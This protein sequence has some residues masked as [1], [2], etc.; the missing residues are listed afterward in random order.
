MQAHEV[1]TRHVITLR[2]E[3]TLGH[4]I[5]LMLR[6]GI[7]GLPVINEH[8]GVV[9]ILTEGDMLRRPEIQTERSR[10][11]W[12]EFL[13]PP[14]T[15]AEEYVH[16]HSLRVMDVMSRHVIAVT[17]DAP[18]SQIV[19]LM[20]R[21]RIKRVPVLDQGKL[22]GIVCRANLIHMLAAIAQDIPG[23]APSDEK[24]RKHL[25]DELNHTRWASWT[26]HDFFVKDGIVDLHGLATDQSEVDALRVAAENIPG[27]KM[28][29]INLML[30]DPMSGQPFQLPEQKSFSPR[31]QDLH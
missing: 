22:V 31:Q 13:V 11:R 8:G 10:S 2:P 24:I 23:T 3:D 29:R 28:V 15:L 9:G 1:M 25:S 5:Q 7:S 6:H 16:S 4:A 27:V 21:H 12:L 20:E 14:A 30:C 17:P 26:S 18:L 19:D